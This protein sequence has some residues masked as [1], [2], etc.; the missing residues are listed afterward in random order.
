M[1]A[2]SSP[3]ACTAPSTFPPPRQIL[4][5]RL[6]AEMSPRPVDGLEVMTRVGQRNRGEDYIATVSWTLMKK[7]RVQQRAK[8]TEKRRTMAVKRVFTTVGHSLQ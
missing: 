8:Y 1:C 4:Q 7:G 2:S 3:G 5:R 6:P